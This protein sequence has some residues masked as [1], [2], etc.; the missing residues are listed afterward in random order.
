MLLLS[1]FELYLCIF[2][3][4]SHVSKKWHPKA[5]MKNE[6]TYILL[7]INVMSYLIMWIDKRS[8]IN[9]RRRISEKTLF[10][11]AIIGGSLGIWLG[12]RSPLF[13]KAAKSKFTVGIPFI[14]LIQFGIIFYY[15][16]YVY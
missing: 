5:Y 12:T 14:F 2:C 6:L 13:H 16:N 8:A 7:L 9:K 10:V 11:F 3:F 4:Y 1:I 15:F